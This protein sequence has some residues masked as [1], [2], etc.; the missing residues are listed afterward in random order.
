LNK[1][2]IFNELENSGLYDLTEI[3]KKKDNLIIKFK[4]EFDDLELQ[5]A[6]SYAN[7]EYEG[8]K[9]DHSWY[10]EYY[11]PYL[12]DTAIDNVEDIMEE[13][14]EEQDIQ[15]EFISCEL[16]KEV[17]K[18]IQFIAAFYEDELNINLDDLILE[19]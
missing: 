14:S 18:S 5:G 16:T 19:L 17:N 1:V 13:I 12:N 4:Y 3:K 11:L 8:D 7:D 10:E 6:E 9:K 2:K 15:Y